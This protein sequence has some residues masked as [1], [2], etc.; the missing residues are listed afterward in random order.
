MIDIH[1][2][3]LPDIDDG[4][5][6]LSLELS[7]AGGIRTGIR[8]FRLP[9]PYAESEEPAGSNGGTQQN[10]PAVYQGSERI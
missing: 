6:Y 1:I 3:N 5:R 4:L 7:I 2:H 10:G 8:Y 9:N